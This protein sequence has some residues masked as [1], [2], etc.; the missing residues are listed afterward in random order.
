MRIVSS[1]PP[2]TIRGSTGTE[3]SDFARIDAAAHGPRNME[4]DRRMFADAE[5]GATGA[6]LRLYA[7]DPPTI[8]LGFHQSEAELDLEAMSRDGVGWV[9]R[10]T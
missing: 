9:R 4:I 1:A 3:L 6:R 7:W 10:P 2:T 5:A 8:S